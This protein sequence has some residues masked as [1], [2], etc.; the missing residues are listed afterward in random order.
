MDDKEN[1]YLNLSDMTISQMYNEGV[2]NILNMFKEIKNTK[3]L[4]FSKFMKIVTRNNRLF[5]IGV[6]LVVIAT[7]LIL[8]N[9]FSGKR[10]MNMQNLPVVYL[11]R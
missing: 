1:I 2:S 8:F 5:Y 4:T 6:L 10:D 9:I 11:D 3:G 7:V